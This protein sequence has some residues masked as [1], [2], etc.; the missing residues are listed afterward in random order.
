MV[1]SRFL[2]GTWKSDAIRTLK[3]V[4]EDPTVK[5]EALRLFENDFFGHL[6]IH[7]TE[8]EYCAYLD[9][10]EDV[11]REYKPYRLLEENDSYFLIESNT[12]LDDGVE[13]K[14]YYKE[15]PDCY[16]ANFGNSRWFEYFVRIF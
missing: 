12:I 3:S 10:E 5:A 4:R 2:L 9:N 8:T 14:K 15:G 7:Y 6:V 13:S 11:E 1:F 16:Y